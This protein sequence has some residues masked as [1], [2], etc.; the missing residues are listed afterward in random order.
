MEHVFLNESMTYILALWD[1]VAWECDDGL[2][3]VSQLQV[4]QVL[5][6]PT[7]LQLHRLR[8]LHV[9]QA[10]CLTRRWNMHTEI[11]VID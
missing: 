6:D 1:E 7:H 2:D 11:D 8:Q 9:Q 4:T 10:G 5:Q 3:A